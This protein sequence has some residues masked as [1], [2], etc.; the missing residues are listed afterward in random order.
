M[1]L[2]YVT[3]A[4]TWMKSENRFDLRA[5]AIFLFKKNVLKQRGHPTFQYPAP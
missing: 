1:E 2:I 4:K 3:Y 5:K